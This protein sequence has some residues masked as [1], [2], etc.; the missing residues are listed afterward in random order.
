[1]KNPRASG[2]ASPGSSRSGVRTT[3]TRR[4][5]IRVRLLKAGDGEVL[6]RL[7]AW[8]RPGDLVPVERCEELL[9]APGNFWS[10]YLAA[11]E[12]GEPIGWIGAHRM[13]R[14]RGDVAF[15]YEI[16]VHPGRRRRGVAT[17]LMARFKDL[18][19]T[20]GI[21]GFFVLTNEANAAAR[22]L[23]ERVGG[24]RRHGD[25]ALFEFRV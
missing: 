17:L 12:N 9:S 22:G 10:F 15:L 14:F 25:E 7:L 4:A 5:S 24:V 8:S 18:C 13:A 20:Q 1:M 16:D 6:R 2:D 23:Y 19:R 21:Q 11:I 3:P